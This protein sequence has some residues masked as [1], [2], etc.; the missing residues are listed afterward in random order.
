MEFRDIGIGIARVFV[1]MAS[2]PGVS[3][4]GIIA[5]TPLNEEKTTPCDELR[6]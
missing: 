1:K 2:G 4:R 3:A 6:R 5:K